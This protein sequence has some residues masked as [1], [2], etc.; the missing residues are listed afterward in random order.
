MYAKGR[1]LRILKKGM[2]MIAN[3]L[4]N[5]FTYN[6]CKMSHST[7]DKVIA[8][9]TIDELTCPYTIA[10]CQN[11]QVPLSCQHLLSTGPDKIVQNHSTLYYSNNLVHLVLHVYL[12]FPKPNLTCQ[13]CAHQV[14]RP[15]SLLCHKIAASQC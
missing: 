15:V 5:Y 4:Q 2:N 9:G 14:T 11:F 7:L 8:I 10:K 3:P 1:I 6:S 13:P 12:Y